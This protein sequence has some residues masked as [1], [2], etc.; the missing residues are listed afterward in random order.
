MRGPGKKLS[1]TIES[2]LPISSSLLDLCIHISRALLTRLFLFHLSKAPKNLK[3][4]GKIFLCIFMVVMS[5][6]FCA[7][8]ILH[9]F[10]AEKWVGKCEKYNDQQKEDF[11]LGTLFPDIRY[12][13]VISREETHETAVTLNEL[14]QEKSAF[15][16]GKKFHSF[17]DLMRANFA[18]K[19]DIH[20]EIKDIPRE[21]RGM[22]LKLIEDEILYSK[23]AWNSI[24]KS[25]T[26]I[27]EEEKN[28]NIA[29][30][31][32]SQWHALLSFY[33]SF[34]PSRILQQ[35]SK[36]KMGY[37]TIPAENIVLWN[38]LL[39]TFTKNEKIRSYIKNLLAEFEETFEEV[40][41]TLIM[42]ETQS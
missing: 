39:P 38:K 32:L 40:S 4:L 9:A 6:G 18:E 37:L 20:T 31:D 33:F 17:V 35:L 23:Q 21:Q 13:G 12:L 25:L 27:H 7:G 36:R 26:D 10:L 42:S 16:K 30:E 3:A 19:W 11:L 22:F 28:Y 1:N 41:S 34:P 15:I 24:C 5:S 29:E 2:V 14:I 8:P